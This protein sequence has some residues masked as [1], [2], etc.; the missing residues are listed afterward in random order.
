MKFMKAAAAISAASVIF[1]GAAIC[2]VPAITETSTTVNAASSVNLNKTQLSLGKGESFELTADQPVTWR[3]SAPKILKVDK[4]GKVTA[5]DN[6]TAWI[7][8]RTNDGT[9]KSCKITVKNEPSRVS[10]S[11]NPLTLGV[12]E[13]YTLSAVIPDD[14]AA[15][16]RTFRTSNSSIIKMTKTNW[17]GSVV[18]VKPGTAWV[19]VRLYNGMEANCKIT[20][21]EAPSK[22]SISK[23]ALSLGIGETYTVYSSLPDGTASSLQQ[24]RTSNSKIVKMTQTNGIGTFTGV[25]EGTAWVTVR[26]FNGKEASCK[27]TVKKAPTSVNISKKTLT[28]TVG[29]TA[30]LSA[31]IPSGQACATRVFRTS[32]SKVIKMTKTDWTGSFKAVGPGTAWVT[33]RT[34]NGKEANC[35][36]QVVTD[37]W[38]QAYQTLINDTVASDRIFDKS[39]TK[40]LLHDMDNDG[41]PELFLSSSKNCN[42]AYKTR[43]YNRIYTVMND[44]TVLIHD[45]YEVSECGV[46]KDKPF[47]VFQGYVQV[48]G[49]NVLQKKGIQFETVIYGYDT[50][51]SYTK[52]TG[53]APVYSINNKSVSKTV[54]DH[55]MKTYLEMNKWYPAVDGEPVTNPVSNVKVK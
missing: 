14:C 49:I 53:E 22:V 19:T 12:G 33:V 51:G 52:I 18:A 2:A 44:K 7:T 38:K 30:S 1:C 28:M 20:V 42:T 29:D 31:S 41:I 15:A 48:H 10:M 21:K 8:A 36:I 11:K 6:G 40:Y 5:V 47:V 50:D 26:T 16:V 13:T 37:E 32:N 35:K 34:Y 43:T 27:V 25:S 24:F 46:C 3:T 39:H 55:R 23:S 45:T 54:Y 4:N 17:T 9:E